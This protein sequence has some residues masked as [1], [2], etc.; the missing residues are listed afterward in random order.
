MAQCCL[1]PCA[2]WSS[3]VQPQETRL[4]GEPA[5]KVTPTQCVFA[6]GGITSNKNLLQR[7]AILALQTYG[8]H[9]GNRGDH[10][11]IHSR[12]PQVSK[13]SAASSPANPPTLACPP[14]SDWKLFSMT[15]GLALPRG[16]L[17]LCA[18]LVVIHLEFP[19]APSSLCPVARDLQ[20]PTC[21]QLRFNKARSAS[22]GK[23]ASWS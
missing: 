20:C 13:R 21:T 8:D 17:Y 14:R 3:T 22:R 9:G 5:A 2:V 6:G 23:H 18:F 16:Q 7:W 10:L 4:L 11:P 19:P 12:K 1:H 15:W